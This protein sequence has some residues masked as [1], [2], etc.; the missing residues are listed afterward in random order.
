MTGANRNPYNIFRIPKS[1]A[2]VTALTTDPPAPITPTRANC[3]APEKVRS[4]IRQLCKTL[5]PAATLAAPKA[6]P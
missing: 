1:E 4:E 5:K 2:V 3:D 6:N